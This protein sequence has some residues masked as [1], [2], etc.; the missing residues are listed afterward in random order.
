MEIKDLSVAVERMDEVRGGRNYIDQ[1]SS[2]GPVRSNV[3]SCRRHVQLKPGK[4]HQR[5]F[6]GQRNG[7]KS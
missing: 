5:C 6:A 7:P 1:Q 3:F 4:H 2:N